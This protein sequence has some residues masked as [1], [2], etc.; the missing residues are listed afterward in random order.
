MEE[1]KGRRMDTIPAFKSFL[2]KMIDSRLGYGK[3]FSCANDVAQSAHISKRNFTNFKVKEGQEPNA[4]VLSK[5]A[6][7]LGFKEDYFMYIWN[8]FAGIE[9]EHPDKKYPEYAITDEL[10]LMASKNEPFFIRSLLLVEQ[11]PD[12]FGYSRG[13]IH[14]E[15][16]LHKLEDIIASESQGNFL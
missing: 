4:T 10:T 1:Q 2:Q 15:K 12:I 7:V 3:A 8:F 9:S 5:M 6:V 16:I 14:L 11:N 13:D